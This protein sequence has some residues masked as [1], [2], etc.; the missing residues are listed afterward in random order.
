MPG[1]AL[2]IPWLQVATMSPDGASRDFPDV[3]SAPRPIW[4]GRA[5]ELKTQKTRS[6][7]VGR[8]LMPE[9]TESTR[10]SLLQSDKTVVSEAG[11]EPG[12]PISE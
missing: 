6:G 2:A 5:L 4:R 10:R 12:M 11:V 8:Q 7:D 3:V 9:A 1:L